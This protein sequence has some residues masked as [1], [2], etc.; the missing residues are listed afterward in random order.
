[1]AGAVMTP[2]VYCDMDGVL[3]DFNAGWK[4]FTGVTITGWMTIS[5]DEW[6]YL[7]K[8]W[9]TFWM[10]LE[11][12]P[13]AQEL[14]RAI[15]PYDPELLTAVPDSWRSA[16]TGKSVWARENLTGN[17]KVH[18]VMRSE[19]K[20]YAREKDGTPNI[21]IDDMEKNIKEWEAAGGVGI[22]YIPSAGMVNKVVRT[23][24][25]HMKRHGA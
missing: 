11:F 17:P 8:Q 25:S 14:W 10:D 21:L 2:K 22:Q 20:N 12:I 16:G 6:R 24:E 15:S 4:E 18:A 23:I 19:K 1:M 9:P 5:G 3:A 13:H 7:K